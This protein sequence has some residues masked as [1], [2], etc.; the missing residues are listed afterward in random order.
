[1]CESLFPQHRYRRIPADTFRYQQIPDT[2]RYQCVEVRPVL[3]T[4]ASS[5]GWRWAHLCPVDGVVVL[6]AS[7]GVGVVHQTQVSNDGAPLSGGV[8]AGTPPQQTHRHIRCV[9]VLKGD[10]LDLKEGQGALS[11]L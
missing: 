8:L 9:V 1:M 11:L 3:S 2:F 10:L 5:E 4:D 7:L 6:G